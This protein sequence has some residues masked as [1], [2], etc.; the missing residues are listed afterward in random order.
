MDRNLYEWLKNEWSISNHVKY[1]K[2]FQEWIEKLTPEQIS[3]FN[4]MKNA[5][6]IKH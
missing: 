3:G 6:Y 1:Q 2:Y 4:K 5:D